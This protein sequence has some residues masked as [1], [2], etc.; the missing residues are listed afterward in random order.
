M[1]ARLHEIINR[2]ESNYNGDFDVTP[3][4]PLVTWADRELLEMVRIL[5]NKV[6]NLENQLLNAIMPGADPSR[7][8]I[9]SSDSEGVK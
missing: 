3:G 7:Y 5:A 6:T 9:A 8:S 4:T 1:D 2:L